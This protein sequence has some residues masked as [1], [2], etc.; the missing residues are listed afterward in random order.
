MLK[1]LENVK[2]ES[3]IVSKLFKNLGNSV[4]KLFQKYDTMGYEVEKSVLFF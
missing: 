2:R 3:S 1:K 4:A